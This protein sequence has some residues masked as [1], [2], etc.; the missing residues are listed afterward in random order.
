MT[1]LGQQ[2][3]FGF[4]VIDLESLGPASARIKTVS[5]TSRILKIFVWKVPLTDT[6]LYTVYRN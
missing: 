1:S 2:N 5:T 3:K 6:V 4:H